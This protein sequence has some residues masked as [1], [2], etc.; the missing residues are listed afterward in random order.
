MKNYTHTNTI[1]I[2]YRFLFLINRT[3][4]KI[5][6]LNN[7]KPIIRRCIKRGSRH[8]DYKGCCNWSI[9]DLF[10]LLYYQTKAHSIKIAHVGLGRH[11][12]SLQDRI[13]HMHIST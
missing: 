6:T 5:L 4:L 1:P 13:K 2:K 8:Y 7:S 10:K 3:I 11:G 12:F 9:N